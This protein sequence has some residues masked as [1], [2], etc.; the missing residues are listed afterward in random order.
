MKI[1]F[2]KRQGVLLDLFDSI[3]WVLNDCHREMHSKFEA[4]VNKDVERAVKALSKIVNKNIELLEV[5]FKEE[6]PLNYPIDKNSDIWGCSDKEELIN[7]IRKLNGQQIKYEAIKSMGEFKEDAD[8]KEKINE[9]L[10]SDI[11]ILDLIESLKVDDNMKWKLLK[12]INNSDKWVREFMQFI[13]GYISQYEQTME[14]YEKSIQVF[15]NYVEENINNDGIKFLEKILGNFKDVF[16]KF[17]DYEEIYVNTIFFNSISCAFHESDKK[18][19]MFLGRDFEA[20]TKRL[21]G[22][23]EFEKNINIF[24]NLCDKTRFNILN[25]L[26]DGEVYSQEIANKY[27]IS[28]ATVSYHMNYLASVK[29]VKSEKR[30]Q[31]TYYV[32]NKDTLRESI[33][34]L[35]KTFKL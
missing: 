28:M 26:M 33:E 29:L 11:K 18:L 19:Y 9:I 14:K 32:V 31:K 20:T 16:L 5:Y 10:Q 24:K 23:N 4:E 27:G 7:F 12:L 8:S 3:S 21:I 35:K 30:A 15:N 17:D 25:Y 22:E 13:E 34:F 6:S 1:I 2:D